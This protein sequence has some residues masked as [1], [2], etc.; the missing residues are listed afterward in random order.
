MGFSSIFENIKKRGL[1][2]IL[3][4]RNIINFFKSYWIKAKGINIPEAE[5]LSY[6][7]QLVYRSIRCYDC[8]KDK[9]C[10]DCSCP[11]PDAAIIKEHVC[12]TGKYHAMLSPSKW[13]EFKRK[14]NFDFKINYYE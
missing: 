8:F 10:H 12:S 7:E 3:N 2:D 14:E 11:Q 1:K 5:I 4:P 9:K 13:E 6:S